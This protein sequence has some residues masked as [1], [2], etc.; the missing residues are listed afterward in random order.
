[1]CVYRKVKESCINVSL[2]YH[3]NINFISLQFHLIHD[4]E[5]HVVAS[6]NPNTLPLNWKE[7]FITEHY[8]DNQAFNTPLKATI[9]NKNISVK[10][11][12]TNEVD[13]IRASEGALD[14]ASEGAV[15][16]DDSEPEITDSSN[17]DVGDSDDSQRDAS[18]A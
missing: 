18:L 14:V 11:Y 4:D 16:N 15:S 6:S 13:K 9:L 7:N 3:P 5:F 1:M 17:N 2:V 8:A 10:V 12:S